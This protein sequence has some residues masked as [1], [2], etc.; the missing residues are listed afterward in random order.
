MCNSYIK[1]DSLMPILI[2]AESIK[3]NTAIK[4]H[5]LPPH[6]SC[7]TGVVLPSLSMDAH[8]SPSSSACD[9]RPARTRAVLEHLNGTGSNVL[10]SLVA[11]SADRPTAADMQI[12]IEAVKL[13]HSA[14]HVQHVKDMTAAAETAAGGTARNSSGSRSTSGS[15][16]DVFFSETTF[17][18][19]VHAAGAG[20]RLVDRIFEPAAVAATAAAAG[21]GTDGSGAAAVPLQRGFALVRPPGHHAGPSTSSGF[22]I[23]NNAA[24]TAAYAIHTYPQ[25]VQRVLVLDLDI[26]HGNGTQ[27]AFYSRSD[28]CTVSMHKQSFSLQG[29]LVEYPEEGR[30]DRVG[31]GAGLGYNV[32]IPLGEDCGDDD[33]YYAFV[34]LVLPLIDQFTPDFIV[35][36][37]GFDASI[38]DHSRPQGGYRVSTNCYE[39]LLHALLLCVPHGRVVCTLEGGYDV[40]GLAV[41]VE[42]S[43]QVLGKFDYKTAQ[44]AAFPMQ[45]QEV[46]VETVAAV[47]AVKDTFRER[48]C[49]L[50]WGTG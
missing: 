22:C 24:I 18:A 10:C 4:K 48:N 23:F 16:A 11:I 7:S 46:A 5:L 29:E 40:H 25:Q 50:W 31:A 14:S 26:H 13:V 1:H 32:N 8:I 30:A 12:G 39:R 47:Q 21:G 20:T 36:A 42:A 6:S 44:H 37:A 49:D 41:N 2:T 43:L 34:H 28:V 38:Y 17:E 35:I 19:A 15:V 27:E 9:E 45:E 33:Y 3:F